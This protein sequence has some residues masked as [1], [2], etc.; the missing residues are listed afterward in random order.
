MTHLLQFSDTDLEHIRKAYRLVTEEGWHLSGAINNC[1]KSITPEA[2]YAQTIRDVLFQ[3]VRYGSLE[4]ALEGR[5]RGFVDPEKAVF[6]SWLRTLITEA[7]PDSTSEVI[8]ASLKNAASYV[9]VN[10]QKATVE[11]C[12]AALSEL[13]PK[14]LAPTTILIQQPYGLFRSA[15]YL[16]GWIEQQ[17]I[18]SQLVGTLLPVQPNTRVVDYCAGSGGKT[19]HLADRMQNAG[20]II[21]L[22]VS[23]HKLTELQKRATRAGATIIETRLLKSTKVAKRLAASAKA[24]LVDAP[25][26]GTGVLR[27]NPDILWHLTEKSLEEL[28]TIQQEVLKRGFVILKPG[29]Y[30]LFATCSLLPQE[31]E[32]QIVSFLSEHKNATLE[33]EV[34]FMPGE[35]GGDGFYTALIKKSDAS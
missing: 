26:S 22:D 28:C 1:F 29:G 34:R 13:K 2:G 7:Y 15:P 31:G 11:Q 17:D 23:E 18:N 25:C 27:R 8:T 19:L 33:K 14:Q 24:V 16:N 21:A 5:L 32:Q 6:P 4:V 35:N 9:R 30:L 3:A 20:K 10:T 12:V